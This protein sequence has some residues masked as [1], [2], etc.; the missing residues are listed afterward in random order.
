MRSSPL[1]SPPPPP[2]PAAHAGGT[3]GFV[4]RATRKIAG[5]IAEVGL[6]MRAPRENR[7]RQPQVLT[8][9]ASRHSRR[10]KMISRLPPKPRG[11]IAALP[12]GGWA[13]TLIIVL[14]S[15]T[16]RHPRLTLRRAIEI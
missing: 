6:V 10:S 1:T 9:R 11:E 14:R 5:K 13:G 7:P 2:P 15:G 12:R 4:N 3:T 8:P 16:L